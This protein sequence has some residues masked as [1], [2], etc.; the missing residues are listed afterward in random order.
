M[1]IK[2]TRQDNIITII[3]TAENIGISFDSTDRLARY[4]HGVC[5]SDHSLLSTTE[6]LNKIDQV[7]SGLLEYAAKKYPENF[8]E[9]R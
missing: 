4:T 7:A 8:L 6:G 9:V 2:E 1:D 3:D 5:V